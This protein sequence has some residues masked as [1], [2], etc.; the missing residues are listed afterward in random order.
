VVLQRGALGGS[1][2]LVAWN[3]S[4]LI[5]NSAGPSTPSGAPS[6]RSFIVQDGVSDNALSHSCDSPKIPPT[7]SARPIHPTE[8]L[9]D[10]GAPDTVVV[11]TSAITGEGI[12]HLRSAIVAAV[13]GDAG[14]VRETGMLTNLRQHQ[15]IAQALAGLDAARAAI[16]SAVPHEMVMLDLY[17]A[18]RGLDAL[19]GATTTEDV[20]RLIF[21]TFCIG[22]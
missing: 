15:A 13:T 2:V 14:G 20:L 19:T 3:K 1:A 17:E 18:L 6:S 9:T 22:K 5:E 21:S 4:D 10:D 8:P 16:S 12:T 7:P 11:Q